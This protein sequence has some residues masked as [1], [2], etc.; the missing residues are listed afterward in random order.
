MR[1][2]YTKARPHY[3]QAKATKDKFGRYFQEYIW[4][5][6]QL[7]VRIALSPTIKLEVSYCFLTLVDFFS[8]CLLA[9]HGDVRP[10][11]IQHI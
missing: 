6:F 9:N 11:Y 4:N 10:R 7:K 5:T 8:I 3:M 1:Q 2:L